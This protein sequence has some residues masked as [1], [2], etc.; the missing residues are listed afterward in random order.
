MQAEL[1]VLGDGNRN[2]YVIGFG[3]CS[4]VGWCGVIED[5]RVASVLVTGANGFVSIRYWL[6]WRRVVGCTKNC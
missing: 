2:V 5:V 1:S 6:C 3:V 4:T